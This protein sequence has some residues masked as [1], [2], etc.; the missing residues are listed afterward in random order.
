MFTKETPLLDAEGEAIVTEAIDCGMV[1]HRVLGPG[2]KERIYDDAMCLEL[3]SRGLKF[4]RQK[5]IE[6]RY[7]SW[8]IPGQKIDLIVGG[9]VLVEIK[10]VSQLKELHSAQVLS[11]LKTTGLRVGL[12]MNFNTRLLKQGLRRV[13]L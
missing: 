6:V 11:Y 10:A 12:L 7:K 3:D 2:Y 5:P 9:V 8:S 1:V 4:E 13:V